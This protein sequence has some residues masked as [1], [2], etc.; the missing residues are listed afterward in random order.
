MGDERNRNLRRFKEIIW[1]QICEEM[2]QSYLYNVM[3]ACEQ[4]VYCCKQHR[5]TPECD[6]RSATPVLARKAA[7][8]TAA[9]YS[10]SMCAK[11]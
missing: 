4:I 6:T 10:T 11:H 7:L 1:Q 3:T 5:S 2:C 9:I 8:F